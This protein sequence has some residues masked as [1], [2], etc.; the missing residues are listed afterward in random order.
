MFY[1]HHVSLNPAE[2]KALRELMKGQI[3]PNVSAVIGTA[4][5]NEAAFRA[6]QSKARKK[7][8]R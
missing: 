7:A 5:I 3:R 6:A 1:R 8:A 2:D 4:L